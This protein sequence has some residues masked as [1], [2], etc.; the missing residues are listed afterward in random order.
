[1]SKL[2]DILNLV[3][4][5]HTTVDLIFQE[6]VQIGSSFGWFRGLNWFLMEVENELYLLYIL[7]VSKFIQ[8]CNHI[9]LTG[10]SIYLQIILTLSNISCYFGLFMLQLLMTRNFHLY[11][12]WK[13]VLDLPIA[14]A[15]PTQTYSSSSSTRAK[16]P[17]FTFWYNFK[18]FPFHFAASAS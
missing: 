11:T 3:I 16:P 10:T 5:V 1:M 17:P 18:N 4:Y 15:H 14:L 9:T 6:Q 2:L 12:T 8:F 13:R 7:C